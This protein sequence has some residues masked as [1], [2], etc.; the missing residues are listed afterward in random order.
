MS[1][2]LRYFRLLK[3]Y[4]EK[5]FSSVFEKYCNNVMSKISHMHEMLY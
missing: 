5:Y 2:V 4:Y 3:I 1:I